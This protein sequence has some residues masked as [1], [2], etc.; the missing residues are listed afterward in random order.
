MRPNP[1]S[2]K[3]HGSE[4]HWLKKSKPHGFQGL[5]Y[6]INRTS[7]KQWKKQ[8]KLHNWLVQLK[9]IMSRIIGFSAIF[10]IRIRQ[11]CRAQGL[12]ARMHIN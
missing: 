5:M 4:K 9:L 12:V 7:T 2:Q 8:T 6:Y 1:L 10:I 11:L 3:D